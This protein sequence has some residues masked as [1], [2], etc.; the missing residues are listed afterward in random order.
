[1]GA[2]EQPIRVKRDLDGLMLLDKPQGMSSNQALQRVKWLLRAKKAGHT[3]TLDPLSTGLLP[4]CFGEATKFSRFQLEADKRYR[5]VGKFGE[6][7]DTAD[8]EGTIV[9]TGVEPDLS[10]ENV[11]AALIGLRGEIEQYPPRYSAIKVDGRRLCDYAR[12][13]ID[14]EIKPRLVRVSQFEVVDRNDLTIL[15]NQ[16]DQCLKFEISCSKGTY[17]RSLIADLGEK[18]GCGAHVVELVRIA[19]GGFT[20][21][22][23][24]TITEFEELA[25]SDQKLAQRLLPTDLLV[26]GLPKQQV[27]DADAVRLNMGQSVVLQQPDNSG[28]VALFLVDEFMGVGEL[29]EGLL[30]PRRL[31]RQ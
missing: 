7:S 28:M 23:A 2:I 1:M 21:D 4:I 10:K 26:T 8:R 11:E 16:A 12:D 25:G 15:E 30:Y 9:S 24:L 13:G 5:V 29:V 18:L 3:G 31:L 19:S 6:V 22:Q 14:V 17:V 27:S 20:L